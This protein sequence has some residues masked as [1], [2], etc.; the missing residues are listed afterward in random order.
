[1]SNKDKKREIIIEQRIPTSILDSQIKP[2]GIVKRKVIWFIGAQRAMKKIW[3]DIIF[4]F[5]PK[6]LIFMF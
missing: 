5:I 1:M 3:I 2:A 6:I 4:V